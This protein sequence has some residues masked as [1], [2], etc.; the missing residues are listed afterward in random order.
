MG[1]HVKN[2][3]QQPMRLLLPHGPVFFV[4]DG[5]SSLV[6]LL[7]HLHSAKPTSDMLRILLVH[8]NIGT[9]AEVFSLEVAGMITTRLHTVTIDV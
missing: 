6:T 4:N 2:D 1:I 5:A 9:I 7:S 8:I 3:R